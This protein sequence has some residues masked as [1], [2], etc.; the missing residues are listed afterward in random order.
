MSQNDIREILFFAIPIGGAVLVLGV[1]G[2]VAYVIGKRS[3]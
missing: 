2:V 3:R 1:V